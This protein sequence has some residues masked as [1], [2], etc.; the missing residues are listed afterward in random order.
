MICP[1]KTQ[2]LFLREKA[3]R[4]RLQT[5]VKEF[6]KMLK[7]ESFFPSGGYMLWRVLSFDLTNVIFAACFTLRGHDTRIDFLWVLFLVARIGPLMQTYRSLLKLN[8]GFRLFNFLQS[9]SWI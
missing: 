8:N 9:A 5:K 7:N 6:T 1:K 2:I 4:R 3:G